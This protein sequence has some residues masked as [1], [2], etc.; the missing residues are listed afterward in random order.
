MQIAVLG[1]TGGV[2]GHVLSRA[3]LDWTIARADVAHFITAALTE[4]TWLRGAAAVA[5]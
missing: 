4:N 5:Y 3:L 2:G 1:G